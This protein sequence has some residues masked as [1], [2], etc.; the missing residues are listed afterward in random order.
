[1]NKKGQF[2]IFMAIL[3]CVY[4]VALVIP[5]AATPADNNFKTLY[6]NYLFE[7]PKVI[8]SAIYN[9]TSPSAQIGNFTQ[10]YITYAQTSESRFGLLYAYSHDGITDIRSYLREDVNI[11]TN[12]T[13]FMLRDN[14]STINGTWFTASASKRTYVFNLTKEVRLQALFISKNDAGAKVFKG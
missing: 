1:M 2:Y 6:E 11:S 3:L 7:A 9:G 5:R 14:A 4:A 8:N 12:T 13:S 10:S